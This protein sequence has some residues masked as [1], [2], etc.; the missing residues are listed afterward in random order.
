MSRIRQ[1]QHLI[2]VSGLTELTD[3][4]GLWLPTVQGFSPP[5]ERLPIGAFHEMAVRGREI[6]PVAVDQDARGGDPCRTASLATS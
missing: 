3:D 2:K 6:G 4:S 5:I 1:G